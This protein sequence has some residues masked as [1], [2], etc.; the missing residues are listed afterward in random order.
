MKTAMK[1]LLILLLLAAG[2]AA[3][4]SGTRPGLGKCNML[5]VDG[6]ALGRYYRDFSTDFSQVRNFTDSIGTAWSNRPFF[7]GFEI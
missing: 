4:L 1:T 6:H 5:H 2:S 3:E 7:R